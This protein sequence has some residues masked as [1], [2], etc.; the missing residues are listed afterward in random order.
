MSSRILHPASRRRRSAFTLVELLIVIIIIGLLMGLMVTAIGRALITAKDS[1]V[2]AEI[3][4]LDAAVKEFKNKYQAFPPAKHDSGTNDAAVKAFLRKAWPR[5]SATGITYANLD[6][7]EVLVYYLGGVPSTSGSSKVTGFD[8]NPTSPAGSGTQ[9]T[10][11]LFEFDQSR[12]KD[13][14]SDGYWEYYPKNSEAPYAY[15]DFT[16]YA[17]PPTS[18]NAGIGYAVPYLDGNSPSG[19]GY[20]NANSFQIIAAGQ[21][22]NYGATGT[23]TFPGGGGYTAEDNDN[24]TNFS[25]KRLEESKP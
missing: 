10:K 14:D 15:F 21:D 19:S 5:M 20:M 12:L 7:P 2:I 18:G 17:S 3:G 11:P 8:L 6:P 24:L 9:R 25:T 22:G 4:Q 13:L 23:K 16:T 1:E